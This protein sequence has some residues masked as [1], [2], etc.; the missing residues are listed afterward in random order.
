MKFVQIL[1]RP[2]RF[3][4]VLL[5]A[6]FVILPSFVLAADSYQFD[7]S[8]ES[9]NFLLNRNDYEIN[10]QET[11]EAAFT[12]KY[13][14]EKHFLLFLKPRF[15]W[16]FLDHER[17]RYWPN[18]TYLKFYGKNS[19][20]SAGF[21]LRSWGV[22]NSFNPTDVINRKDFGDNFFVPEKLGDMLFAFKN[23]TP[24]IGIFEDVSFEFIGLPWFLQT[25]LPG[26]NSR[27]AVA[28]TISGFRFTQYDVQDTPDFWRSLGAGFRVSATTGSLDTDVLLYHGPEKQPTFFMMLDDNF[29]LRAVPYYYDIDM[30]GFNIAKSAGAFVWHLESALKI[31]EFN[32]VKNH[33]IP[34]SSTD[35][36]P[37]T[38]L[39]FVPGVDYTFDGVFGGGTWIWTLEYLGEDNTSVVVEEFRPFKS[40]VFLGFR[41]EFN[42]PKLTR[43]EAGIL[44]DVFNQ[45]MIIK[46]QFHT[47]LVGALGLDVEAIVLNQDSDPEAPLSLFENNT[48]VALKLG[49]AFGR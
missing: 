23:T 30:L 32:P 37:N 2:V 9:L 26:V 19:E 28:G 46:S 35:V 31:T 24:K 18:E 38:Y 39:Q 7:L 10:D 40:D 42:N 1:Y 22:A 25:P 41:Y 8:Y 44:K 3:W 15:K 48:Y 27:F 12:Y 47:S 36:V 34:F 21:Q 11:V 14:N 16:D 29:S 45:E 20:V 5:C 49:Y 43:L 4:I 33:A 17:N 13:D 6:V